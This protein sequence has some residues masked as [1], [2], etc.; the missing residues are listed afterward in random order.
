LLLLVFLS[1]PLLNTLAQAIKTPV[2]SREALRK[3]AQD[4]ACTLIDGKFGP[5]PCYHLSHAVVEWI[6]KHQNASCARGIAQVK[7]KREKWR[8]GEREREKIRKTASAPSPDFNWDLWPLTWKISSFLHLLLVVVW[9]NPIITLSFVA[10]ILLGYVV[11][12]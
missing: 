9:F 12:I 7:R 11:V 5:L 4:I 1:P 10:L 2:D 6:F 8:K 3:A